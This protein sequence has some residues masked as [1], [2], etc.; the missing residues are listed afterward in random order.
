MASPRISLI[1]PT[2]NRAA[3]LARCLASIAGN[4]FSSYEVVVVDQSST[5]ATLAIIKKY[6]ARLV[7]LP[8]PAGYLPP[9]TSRNAGFEVSRGGL[10]YHL[11]SDMEL[12]PGLLTEI[13][14]LFRDRSVSAAVVPEVDV[15]DNFW[16]A[17]KAFERSLYFGTPMEGA[18]VSRRAIF[19]KVG[20]DPVVVSG[21][22]WHIHAQ[23]AEHGRIVRTTKTVRHYLGAV[24]LSAEFA[25]KSQ[26]GGQSVA[27][28]SRHHRELTSLSLSLVRLYTVGIVTNLFIQPRVV[29]AFLIIRSV[30]A[31]AL[32]W[33]LL[34]SRW[35][36]AGSG[37]TPLSPQS[38]IPLTGR[39]LYSVGLLPA[40]G[41]RLLVVGDSYGWYAR[42][43][44]DHGAH[45]VHSLDIAAPSA[46]IANLT[47]THP[48]FRHYQASILDFSATRR[49]DQVIFLEVI[50]HLPVG[51]EV[52]AL[53]NI[54]GCLEPH[55]CL[56]L[57]TPAASLVSYL[58][59]PA[60]PLGH[61]HYSVA[62][63]AALLKQ[64]GFTNSHF[65]RGGFIWSA[66]DILALYFTK[67]VLRRPYLSP[68]TGR[69]NQEYPHLSGI[70]LFA[71]S[72]K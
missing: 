9:A 16:A 21:E 8:A 49:Y 44:L 53:K 28:T 39:L 45:L 72:R 5:D 56:L 32:V 12:E 22:D 35:Y 2:K 66:L 46:T 10:I 27:Y 67:W 59:D 3:H 64:A 57:S 50:E 37:R 41:H 70:T 38:V 55:G 71:I 62:S 15:P 68:W 18:R 24:S 20:Y 47:T 14:G 65:T 4:G 17:G 1:I 7:T 26:Y 58:A 42:Y 31:M 34:A 29:L 36:F 48:N 6:H 40:A 60:W 25:K 61:R 51:A 54:Y 52:S 30:D 13:A 19:A 43:A 69:I 63:L 23:L 33:G 11:D